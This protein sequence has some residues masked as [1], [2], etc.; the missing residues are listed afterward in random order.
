MKVTFLL[1]NNEYVE[2]APEK[3]QIR[4]ISSGLSAL[5]YEVTVPLKNEDGSPQLN[6]D[7][8]PKTQTG[9]RPFINYA[10]NLY[11]P[12]ASPEE[13]IKN[14]KVIIKAKQAEIKAAADAAE[15]AQKAAAAEAKGKVKAAKRRVN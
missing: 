9:F 3:L 14:L 15:A 12:G 13:D 10:V 7:G 4:Q 11:V 1:D 8:S 5:G 2:V 6:E